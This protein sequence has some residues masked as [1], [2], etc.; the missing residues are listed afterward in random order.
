[1]PKLSLTMLLTA[2]AACLALPAVA[3]EFGGPFEGRHVAHGKI[4]QH[5]REIHRAPR[6]YRYSPLRAQRYRYLPPAYYPA[7]VPPYG[8]YYAPAPAPYHA[9]DAPHYHDD[10]RRQRSRYRW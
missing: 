10:H 3:G 7:P 6:Y 1:M 9:H 8:G 4:A 2:G 5:P